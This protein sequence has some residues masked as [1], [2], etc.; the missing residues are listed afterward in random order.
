[1]SKVNN[2]VN[3]RNEYDSKILFSECGRFQND[4]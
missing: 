4:S 3:S 1:M 2:I